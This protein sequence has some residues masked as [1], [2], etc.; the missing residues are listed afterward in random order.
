[1]YL[2]AQDP[3]VGR[4]WFANMVS[5]IGARRQN[6]NGFLRRNLLSDFRT[7]QRP[8]YRA[9][10][11]SLYTLCYD[12]QKLPLKGRTIDKIS[13]AS[14]VNTALPNELDRLDL[15]FVSTQIRREIQQQRH[16]HSPLP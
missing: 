4:Q 10:G 14:E 11:N 1:M 6:L 13:R 2:V 15:G 9:S 8:K 3:E 12:G 5:Q 7:G 16:L